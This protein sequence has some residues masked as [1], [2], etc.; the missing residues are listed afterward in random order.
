MPVDA[1]TAGGMPMVSN[2][3]TKAASGT[4][5]GLMTPF[6]NPSAESCTMAIG[7]TSLPVPDVVGTHTS[8]VLRP[9]SLPMPNTSAI[10]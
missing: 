10:C 6:F 7:E 9:A 2:G 8:G 1:V 3:S 5:C 4:R